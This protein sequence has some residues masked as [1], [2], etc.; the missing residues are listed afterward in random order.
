[1]VEVMEI[2]QARVLGRIA[3]PATL[4][5]GDFFMAGDTCFIGTGLRTNP[6]VRLTQCPVC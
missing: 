4:E 2:L 3:A 6:L 1:M 5:G